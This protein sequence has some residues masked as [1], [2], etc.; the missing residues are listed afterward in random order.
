MRKK[1]KLW[2]YALTSALAVS[3]LGV[4][5]VPMTAMAAA[6]T[7]PIQ[8]SGV[9]YTD[10]YASEYTA[11]KDAYI[12]SV[13]M[14][15]A[16]LLKDG[17]TNVTLE[18]NVQDS[19]IAATMTADEKKETADTYVYGFVLSK[20][21][22]ELAY[23]KLADND[24]A[25][26][27]IYQ[28]YK[29]NTEVSVDEIAGDYTITLWAKD[30]DE[31][32]VA[33]TPGSNWTNSKSAGKYSVGRHANIVDVHETGF[34]K[35]VSI[36]TV[37]E[38]GTVADANGEGVKSITYADLLKD[39]SSANA[40]SYAVGVEKVGE[41]KKYN[42]AKFA[43][44]KGGTHAL[45]NP[46]TDVALTSSYF[47]WTDTANKKTYG[48]VAGDGSWTAFSTAPITADTTLKNY[49][50]STAPVALNYDLGFVVNGSDEAN[51]LTTEVYKVG[52]S[53][54]GLLDLS[55][56]DGLNGMSFK[57]WSTEKNG[58]TTV[59]NI[60]VKETSNN[61]MDLYAVWEKSSSELLVMYDHTGNNTV[62]KN[63]AK[64]TGKDFTKA[65]AVGK[66]SVTLPKTDGN[67]V[68]GSTFIG[69]TDKAGS[70]KVSYEP[71]AEY[72]YTGEGEIEKRLAEYT[73]DI[74]SSSDLETAFKVDD[75]NA[76]KYYSVVNVYGAYEIGAEVK[77]DDGT[78]AIG[79][80]AAIAYYVSEDDLKAKGWETTTVTAPGV[81]FVDTTKTA[82]TLGD[83]NVDDDEIGLVY[84]KK[85]NLI[86]F[87]DL[88]KLTSKDGEYKFIG[89][90]TE[91]D[92]KSGKVTFEDGAE[93]T[94]EAGG[95]ISGNTTLYAMYEPQ[96]EYTV[97]FVANRATDGNNSNSGAANTPFYKGTAQ[98]LT[99]IAARGW[100]WTGHRFLGWSEDQNA[101]AATIMDGEEYTATKDTVLYGIWTDAT[102]ADE[103]ETV[104]N[105]DAAAD[106]A[107]AD[108][109]EANVAALE[110]AIDEART[111]GASD[112]KIKALTDKLATALKTAKAN[113]EKD[114]ANQKIAAENATKEANAAKADAATQ[115]ANAD[116]ANKKNAELQK[117]V[118]AQFVTAKKAKATNG[119]VVNTFAN[120]QATLV[121][122]P[123][124]KTKATMTLASKVTVNGKT[125]KVTA[126]AAKALKSN[127]KIK[128]L[129]VPATVKQIGANAFGSKVTKLTV[130]GSNVQVLNNALKSI[131]KSAKVVAKNAYTLTQLKTFGKA[132][133]TVKFS[134]K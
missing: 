68:T 58:T 121:S 30:E 86:K 93:V 27:D 10:N 119:Y 54:T 73:S 24:T 26:V 120:G 118:D 102:E 61:Q 32:G 50:T 40:N 131:N 100:V 123:A 76:V 59:E 99:K 9:K 11:S 133:K 65:I 122:I 114:A 52:E 79:G 46:I 66:N 55:G 125:Y 48:G 101:K 56:Y 117:T 77:F 29:D 3:N 36:V 1:N 115:K 12:G 44:L 103:T 57:G 33:K 49:I 4:I 134:K 128:T 113:A 34:S 78:G 116:A 74:D 110:K 105:A 111:A 64:S 39:N 97:T 16:E 112:D 80:K 28:K 104:K 13:A 51:V 72:K 8:A 132:K 37:T 14:T 31:D 88:Y 5:A 129:T 38:Q 70:T 53:V 98:E 20:N 81:A 83:N 96:E 35:T 47:G 25:A 75:A 18:I 41:T 43:V 106:K 19:D 90:S 107:V 22:E 95:I 45:S 94:L 124:A 126:I 130:K 91:K 7:A 17:E 6:P 15:E 92:L 127:T 60:T 87:S 42:T 62:D 109:S 71:G 89:W 21:G 2:S 85:A 84:G 67:P 82:G 63:G 23:G 69:W 108:P